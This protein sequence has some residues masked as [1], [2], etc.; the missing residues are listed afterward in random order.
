MRHTGKPEKAFSMER[1]DITF[2]SALKGRDEQHA[3]EYQ[4]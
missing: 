3:T 2:L 4:R 1:G